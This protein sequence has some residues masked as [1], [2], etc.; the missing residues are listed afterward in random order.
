MKISTE[1]PTEL[2]V[3]QTWG[4]YSEELELSDPMPP[5]DD[6]WECDTKI[7][8]IFTITKI[9]DN[10]NV[11]GQSVYRDGM[12]YGGDRVGKEILSNPNWIYLSTEL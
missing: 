10:G 12:A 1:V 7:T 8:Y 3:G 4:F 9:Y 2:L 11:K 6:V 5:E